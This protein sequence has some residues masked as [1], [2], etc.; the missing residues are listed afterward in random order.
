LIPPL[1]DMATHKSELPAR[2]RLLARIAH[3]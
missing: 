3:T 1:F 2:V